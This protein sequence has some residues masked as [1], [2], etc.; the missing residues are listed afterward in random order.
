MRAAM[1]VDGDAVG[2]RCG[3]QVSEAAF[4]SSAWELSYHDEWVAA[5]GAGGPFGRD[6][7]WGR[8]EV[9]VG[10]PLG[11]PVAARLLDRRRRHQLMRCS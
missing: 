9:V 4:F 10:P 7:G 8:R 2:D 6:E 5:G 3:L 11:E 1:N